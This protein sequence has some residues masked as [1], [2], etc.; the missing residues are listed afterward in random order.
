MSEE[1]KVDETNEEDNQ[2]FITNYITYCWKKVK[3]HPDEIALVFTIPTKSQWKQLSEEQ[4]IDNNINDETVIEAKLV[5]QLY[6]KRYNLIRG[7]KWE[8]MKNAFIAR[9]NE[10]DVPPEGNQYFLE[11]RTDNVKGIETMEETAFVL[12]KQAFIHYIFIDNNENTEFCKTENTKIKLFPLNEEQ[13]CQLQ[14]GAEILMINVSDENKQML[15]ANLSNAEMDD[16]ELEMKMCKLYLDSVIH[17]RT[18]RCFWFPSQH[19]NTEDEYEK[20]EHRR[21]YWLYNAKRQ[22][23]SSKLRKV[24]KKLFQL[25]TQNEIGDDDFKAAFIYYLF[26]SEVKHISKKTY[27]LTNDVNENDEKNH[28]TSST[29]EENHNTSSAIEENHNTSSAIEEN[30]NTSSAIEEKETEIKINETN[31]N[32]LQL[33]TPVKRTIRRKKISATPSPAATA[34]TSA[35]TANTSAATANTSAAVEEATA[36]TATEAK[37]ANDE[38]DIRN[39]SQQLATSCVVSQSPDAKYNIGL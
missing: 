19:L 7:R 23:R 27:P 5:Y 38:N 24:F 2:E 34:N 36:A 20:E 13:L 1:N 15:I 31:G 17:D 28:N 8:S 21:W 39:V 18:N 16:V 6:L 9:L 30:H 25:D 22:N 10:M 12:F 35:A 3:K 14:Q 33:V 4:K 32:I 37:A 11:K 26:D 29:I